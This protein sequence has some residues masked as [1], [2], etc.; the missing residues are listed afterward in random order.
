MNAAPCALV[1]DD[2]QAARHRVA[3]LLQLAG[4]RVYEAVGVQDAVRAAAQLDPGL[5]V[6]EQRLRDGSGADLVRGLRG[7]GSRARF[8]FVTARPTASSRAEAAA[9]G[10]PCL[11]KPVQPAE[12]VRFLR[13]RPEEPPAPDPLYVRAVRCDFPGGAAA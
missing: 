4:W 6:T 1:V 13:G 12:L 8:L 5:V 9:A 7:A 10:V 2:A 11:A 3:V